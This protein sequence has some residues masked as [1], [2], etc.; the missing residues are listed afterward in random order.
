MKTDPDLVA[1]ADENF[2]ASFRKLTD[3]VPEGACREA[4]GL[5][6]FATGLPMALFNGCV[7]T[8][9]VDPA[10]LDSAVAWVRTSNAPFRVWVSA[11][12]GAERAHLGQA[13]GL[14]AQEAPYPGM[15]LHPVPDPPAPATGVTVAPV[16]PDGSDD[17]LAVL[18]E[19]GLERDL[20]LRLF[21]HGFASDPAVALFLAR[22]DGDPV[23]VSLAISSD[24]A[25]GVYN[26]VTLERA[27]RRGVGT[28]LTWAAVAAGTAWGRD[29]IVLQSSPMAE[30]MYR[31][32]GFRLVAP[33]AV[34][35]STS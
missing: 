34:F 24:S 17:F 22:I 2:I 11:G 16:D 21:L 32:M 26:V 28:A 12:L 25:S 30:S 23:G 9:S 4:P 20:A 5:F 18:V 6:A 7:V 8:G 15:A 13:P 10:E 35:S 27:R 14:A 1:A 31:A 29:T 3:H 19:A 33:Y